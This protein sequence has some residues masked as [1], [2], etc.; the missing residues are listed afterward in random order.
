MSAVWNRWIGRS[1]SNSSTSRKRKTQNRR[2][3]PESLEA[4]QLLAANI[5]HNEAM[6]EDV[7]E[8]G[9]VSAVDALTIINQINT[10]TAEGQSIDGGGLQARGRGRMTDVNNDGRDS[11]LDALMVINRLNREQ[12][13]FDPPSQQ[14]GSG[15]LP[16]DGQNQ[17]DDR[18]G[19][20]TP[21][22][23][24]EVRSIDGTGNNLENTELGAAN[25]TLLRVA[26]NDYA[27]GI[28]ES[29][30][31]D[32]PS[33]REISNTLSAA[34]PDGTSS[35]R[36]L[37]SFVFM[38]GQFLDHDIDLSLEPED[39]AD[40]ESF[41][42]EVPTGDPLFDPFVTGEATIHLTRSE[43]AEGTGTSVDNPAEQVNAI[44]AWIDGSQVYGSSEDVAN[45]LREFEGGRM[46][47]T[48]DGLVP[49]D[50]NGSL[51][52]G[53]IRAAEN[54][55]LTSMH[56]LFL[57]EHNRLADEIAADNPDLTDEEIY[58]QAREIVIAELQSITYNE[59]LPALLGEDAL[60]NYSGYD[61][62][63]DPSI[64]NEFSTAAFRFGHT[65][66]NDTIGFY[67]NDGL[68]VQ[69]AVS[70]AQAFFNSSMLE[71]TGI[72]SILK[73]GA[74]T[75]S[76]E[77]DL[78]VVDSLRNFLFG[79]PG[80]GGLDLVSLNIQ[81]GRDHGLADFNSVREAYGLETF[82]SFAEITSDVELQEKLETLYGDVNNIDLWVGLLAEDHAA[83]SSLGETATTIIADQFERLRD[84]D[85]FFYENTFSGSELR[86]IENTTLAD[87]IERN[88]NNESLQS[89]VF[90]FT[91][92][93]AGTVTA[94]QVVAQQ[95]TNQNR[96]NRRSGR[97]SDN[98]TT[99]IAMEGMEMEL[100][101]SDG[102]VVDTAVTDGDGRYEFDSF[103]R[104][105][106]YSI[107]MASSDVD[108]L[109]EDTIEVLVS[110]GDVHLDTMDFKVSV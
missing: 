87:I 7:N 57:R 76:Q 91:P 1:R 35:E 37:S 36:D 19:E 106:V 23:E 86:E 2:L 75:L 94:D 15:Q 22:D 103:D 79:A 81:R 80:S 85:R 89:N 24:T 63:V 60:D 72:D 78:E 41:D 45:S 61:S 100:L 65:T 59:F 107:R 50:E 66:L 55:G 56:A 64:A 110:S 54:I 68:D 71:D 48:E 16:G 25:T 9:I 105:G 74:S 28:S 20:D 33:A 30:G 96:N 102:N 46:L 10:Q 92:T 13:R 53:D 67:G 11:A 8:D 27:D 3:R 109:G 21:A 88:T 97:P 99:T 58:Q 4:R 95:A 26:D 17:G 29:G 38:W 32:R 40:A 44:T 51:L 69:D 82:D 6:P 83:D 31:E 108:V 47:I 43:I 84:G 77:T 104:T 73:A 39:D 70:L 49:T 90:F 12:G 52:A 62:S 34:D 93:I 98:E 101:D 14:P 18:P 42:I 5:F